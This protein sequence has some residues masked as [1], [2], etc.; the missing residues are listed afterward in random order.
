MI[1]PWCLLA[2]SLAAFLAS[3]PAR[4]AWDE[5]QLIMWQA[6]SPARMAGLK[7]LGFSGTALIAS[8]GRIDPALLQT[9]RASGMRWYL[10]N[11]ATDFYAPYH[12]YTPGKSV[13]WLWDEV[14]ARRRAKPEDTSVFLRDPS[15]SDP[16]WR[17][18]IADRLSRMV[19]TNQADR[20]LFYNLADE[21]GIGD[22]AAA[23]DA[24][25]SPASLDGMRSWLRSRYA[26]LDALNRQWGTAYA[27]WADVQPELTDAALRRTDG[28]Y[29]AWSDFKAWMDVAFADALRHGADAVH[30]A[31]PAALAGL[32][33]AQI[34]G[35]GGYDYGLL[36]QSVDV[37]EIYDAGQAM[38]L[39]RAFNP[40]LITL[41]TSFGQGPGEIHQAWSSVLRGSR[42]IIVWDEADD[43]V[44]DDGSAGPRG[45]EL[46]ALAAGIRGVAPVLWRSA[47]HT[48]PVAVLYSQASFRT[49][50][51]LDR[52]AGAPWADRDAEREWDDNAWRAAR[53]QVSERLAQIGVAPRH[54]STQMVEAGML[55]AG[56]RSG[57]RVLMLPHAIALSD[58]EIQAIRAF[59][60]AG[61]TVLADTEPGIWDAH[62]RRRSAPPLADVVQM[63]Q[64]VRPD[65]DPA[66][67]ASL[68]ALGSLLREAGVVPRIGIEGAAPGF[69]LRTF[70]DGAAWLVA[71]QRQAPG[72][73]P[74][75]V[76]LHWPAQMMVE[77]VRSGRTLGAMRQ[78]SLTPDAVQPTLLRLSP[79]QP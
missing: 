42:G 69:D 36:A 74:A 76:T 23:W 17:T 53:R 52:R 30:A 31:D 25:V 77:D 24:D 62:S 72:S 50:W 48:D 56:M 3:N 44:A 63:P 64:T 8:G 22:L 7:R 34:P 54:L 12:R 35:W 40:A 55:D 11:I 29:S 27:Q 4:A 16:A 32:E 13:T 75:S 47:P 65:A 37:M 2:A 15:L 43:V 49:Q 26:D 60:A 5:F 33:G 41:R 28:N 6:Q 57:V 39:A 68:T 1:R 66:N 19:Q 20:P 73:G 46:S 18:A 79:V 21:A 14:R 38:D 70:D 9:R 59:K 58:R 71:I 67:P 10:E 61:G 78:V 45:R 51:L